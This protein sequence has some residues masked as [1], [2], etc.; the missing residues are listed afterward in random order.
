MRT[1]YRNVY[2]DST[3][4]CYLGSG[5]YEDREEA[6]MASARRAEWGV[7]TIYRIWFKTKRVPA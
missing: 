5:D 6:E 7:R 2:Q 1:F 4:G 3:Y